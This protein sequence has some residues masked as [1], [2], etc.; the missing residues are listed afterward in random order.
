MSSWSICPE[1]NCSGSAFVFYLEYMQGLHVH[2][3]YLLP[4]CA[5]LI[6]LLRKSLRRPMLTRLFCVIL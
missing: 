6:V 2:V 4:T 1:D 5:W 3:Q